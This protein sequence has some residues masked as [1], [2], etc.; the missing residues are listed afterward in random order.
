M[1]TYLRIFLW[2]SIFFTTLL[3]V[4]IVYFFDFSF[5]RLDSLSE[6][7]KEKVF[8]HVLYAVFFI[9]FFLVPPCYLVSGKSRYYYSVYIGEDP[10]RYKCL[11][12]VLFFLNA[13]Y[14]ALLS[15]LHFDIIPLYSIFK[16]GT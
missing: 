14:L 16:G 2:Y 3:G 10:S 4:A 15:I 1:P 12:F 8:F 9:F 7:V 13:L 5:F 11:A 6:E